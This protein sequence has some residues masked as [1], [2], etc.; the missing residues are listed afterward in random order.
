[1]QQIKT[2]R[3]AGRQNITGL[4]LTKVFLQD[5]AILIADHTVDKVVNQGFCATAIHAASS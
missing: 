4:A 2:L 5:D 3:Q 1:V